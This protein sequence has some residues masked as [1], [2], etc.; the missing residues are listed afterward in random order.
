[1]MFLKDVA[2]PRETQSNLSNADF[3]ETDET[4]MDV[5]LGEGTETQMTNVPSP[6]VLDNDIVQQQEALKKSRKNKTTDQVCV[7]PDSVRPPKMR[8]KPP[9]SEFEEQLLL[10]EKEKINAL[11]EP[12]DDDLMFFKSLTPYFKQM[13]P[14]QKLKVR[15]KIQQVVIDELSVWSITSPASNSGGSTTGSNLQTYNYGPGYENF[16]VM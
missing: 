7:K 5:S 16:D 11:K 4:N 10:N 6:S 12:E 1:M 2:T 9:M 13:T 15:S 3:N 8:K 14:L